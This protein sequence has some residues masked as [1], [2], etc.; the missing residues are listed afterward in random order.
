MAPA[1]SAEL[2]AMRRALELA[3][4]PG[5]PT[6]PN[7]RVGCVLLGDDGGTLG[8]GFH[9]GA[10][11]PHAEVDALRGAGDRARGA[12]AV[13]TLEPCSHT[14]RTGPCTEALIEAGV[15]RVCYAQADPNPVAAGGAAAL[16]AAGVDVEGGLL[17]ERAHAVNRTWSF[18]MRHGR[19]FVTW[20]LASTLDGRIAAADGSSRWITSRAARDDAHRLRAECDVILVGTGTVLVDDPQLTVR[21][22]DGE[23]TAMQP[24]RAVMGHRPIPGSHRVLDDAAETTVLATHDPTA[25]LQELYR[26][27][28]QHVLLEGGATLAAAF[29]TAGLVDEVVAYVA[30]AL[31][32]TGTPSVGELGIET[33]ADM[34]RFA[35]GDVSTIGQ[36]SEACVRITMSPKG[37]G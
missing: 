30:P 21:G 22:S 28:R 37:G 26:H 34:V 10:G 35:I 17:E 24:L 16:A 19:P 23:P 25:A 27:D 31:L 32:G 9:R 5:V 1:G 2:A 11:T 33:I 18:A 36:G 12:T 6:G 15:R 8:E 4:S 13:V 29:L 14:G 3:R 20:K 7:P